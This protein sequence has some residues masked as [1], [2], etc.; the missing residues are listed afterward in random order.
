M[1]SKGEE[2]GGSSEDL[3]DEKMFREVV[4]MWV[5]ERC[6]EHGYFLFMCPIRQEKHVF[7]AEQKKSDWIENCEH[8]EVKEEKRDHLS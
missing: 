3:H 4:F 5:L 2:K 7:C 1:T 8:I 6:F